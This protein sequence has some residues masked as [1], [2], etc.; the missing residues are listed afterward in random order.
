MRGFVSFKR[1][2]CLVFE[3]NGIKYNVKYTNF[4]FGPEKFLDETATFSQSIL[5]IYDGENLLLLG[6]FEEKICL[7][8]TGHLAE[9]EFFHK[10]VFT[11]KMFVYINRDD[12]F[13]IPMKGEAK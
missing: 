8:L 2:R 6:K 12:I 9:F 7:K 4:S 11:D 3:V 5:N 1:P 13:R 10:F